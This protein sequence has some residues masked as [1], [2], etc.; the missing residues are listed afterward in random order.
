MYTHTHMHTLMHTHAHTHMHTHTHTL[1]HTYTHT[2]TTYFPAV[3]WY[4]ITSTAG[5][6]PMEQDGTFTSA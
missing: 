5:E 2:H 3:H 4:G 1:T 6:S